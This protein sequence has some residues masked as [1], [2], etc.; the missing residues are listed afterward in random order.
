MEEGFTVVWSSNLN[1]FF[2]EITGMNWHYADALD[3]PS[4]NSM[5][6]V[7]IPDMEYSEDTDGD[8][9]WEP[10]FSWQRWLN[11]GEFY[12]ADYSAGRVPS[13]DHV[14]QWLYENGHIPAGKY[15]LEV[16]W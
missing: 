10:G 15:I 6:K 11:G 16:W 12:D 1:R 14:F 8:P 7:V 3:Y 4:Q 5:T 2:N 9:E 13:V